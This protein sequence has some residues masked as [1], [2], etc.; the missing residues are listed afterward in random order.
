MLSCQEATRLMS[1]KLD[2]KLALVEVMNL[3]FHLMMCKGCRH[4]DDQMLSLR[5]ITRAYAKGRGAAAALPPEG[6]G[7]S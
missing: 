2:R 3:R 4:F 7:E 1:Q 5:Q 6:D